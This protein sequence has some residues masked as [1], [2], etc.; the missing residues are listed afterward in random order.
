MNDIHRWLEKRLSWAP[1]DIQVV[2]YRA[3]WI[4]LN[5]MIGWIFTGRPQGVA[6]TYKTINIY[7]HLTYEFITQNLYIIIVD[8][9]QQASMITALNFV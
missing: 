2:L 1:R 9:M 4:S 6:P 3:S 8:L 7:I 5:A